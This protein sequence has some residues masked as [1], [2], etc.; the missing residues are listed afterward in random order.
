MALRIPK[1][2]EP[3]RLSLGDAFAHLLRHTIKPEA[4]I[5]LAAAVHFAAMRVH[6]RSTLTAAQAQI[7]LPVLDFLDTD[8]IDIVLAIE[9]GIKSSA[10]SV[11]GLPGHFIKE[12]IARPAVDDWVSGLVFVVINGQRKCFYPTLSRAE[13]D[14]SFEVGKASDEQPSAAGEAAPVAEAEPVAQ[15]GPV[16][17]ATLVSFI[18]SL[19]G[20]ERLTETTARARAANHIAPKTFTDAQWRSAWKDEP[21]KLKPGERLQRQPGS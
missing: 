10:L 14:A 9:D 3:L 13:V 6:M 15:A 2:N 21:N 16:A 1:R 5:D 4:V 20:S 18:R 17:A 8:P 7:A 11:E 19:M 12:W